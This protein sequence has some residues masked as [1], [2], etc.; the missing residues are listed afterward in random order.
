[1]LTLAVHN[2]TQTW[3][4][5]PSFNSSATGRRNRVA[6][7]LGPIACFAPCDFCGSKDALST[8]HRGGDRISG[9]AILRTD[10]VPRNTGQVHGLRPPRTVAKDGQDDRQVNSCARKKKVRRS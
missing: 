7:R 1:M 8:S 6:L 3:A 9:V 2:S 5:R 10:G 4:M